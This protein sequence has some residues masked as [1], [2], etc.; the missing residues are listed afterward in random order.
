M[1]YCVC[2]GQIQTETQDEGYTALIEY[3]DSGAEG[4]R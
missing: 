1:Q 4:G 3:M 2:N